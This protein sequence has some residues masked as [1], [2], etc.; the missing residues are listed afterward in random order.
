ME[1]EPLSLKE[2]IDS[3][4]S[5]TFNNIST[6]KRQAL[7]GLK[8]RKDIVIRKADKGGAIVELNDSDYIIEALRQLNNSSTYS[9]LRSDPRE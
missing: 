8:N 2:M 4:A 3:T 1:K 5:R 6:S 9:L 7:T